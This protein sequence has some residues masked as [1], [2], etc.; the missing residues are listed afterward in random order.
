MNEK[1]KYK[2][3]YDKMRE[4]GE[5]YEDIAVLTGLSTFSV[6]KKFEGITNWTIHEIDILCKHYETPYEELFK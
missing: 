1:I 3:L 4:R 2:I 5:R 6:R